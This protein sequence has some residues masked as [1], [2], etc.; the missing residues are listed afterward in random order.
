MKQKNLKIL[1]WSASI[2]WMGV[3]FVSSSISDFSTITGD[4]DDRSDLLSSIVHIVFF[5]VL[6]GLLTKSFMA[7]GLSNKKSI[8]YAFLITIVYGALDEF[9]QSFVPGREVHL[10]DWLLDAIGALAIAKFYS[11]RIKK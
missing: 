2:L 7:S 5:A 11:H 9:H 4:S 3:I 10:S 8:A 1:Y 6:A